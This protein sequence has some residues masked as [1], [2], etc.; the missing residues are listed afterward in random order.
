KHGKLHSENKVKNFWSLTL[1]KRSKDKARNKQQ[2]AT[3]PVRPNPTK[4][5]KTYTMDE[6]VPLT[7]QSLNTSGLAS[8]ISQII[9]GS[10][11]SIFRVVKPN[12]TF[13]YENEK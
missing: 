4:Q 10:R 1:R 11:G 6:D 9:S 13:E 2:E 3:W 12:I 8:N 5:I 7:S